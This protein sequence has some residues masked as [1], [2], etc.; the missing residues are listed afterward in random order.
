MPVGNAKERYRRKGGIRSIDRWRNGK[1]PL[2]WLIDDF[3]QNKFCITNDWQFHVLVGQPAEG[4]RDIITL[5]DSQSP[6]I[7]EQIFSYLDYESLIN[8]EKVS[9]DWKD[10]LKNE[11]I[12]KALIKR[13][14]AQDPMWRTF[15]NQF[16]RS[17]VMSHPVSPAGDDIYYMSRKICQE[18]ESLKH[19]YI[20]LVSSSVSLLSSSIT[21]ITRVVDMI[22]HIGFWDSSQESDDC[23]D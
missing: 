12:W 10:V 18:V 15:F 7:V 5:L 4:S 22:K 2:V 23:D 3:E 14:V 19:Q 13:N 11:R 8:A 20:A 1:W 16:K 6:L 21:L 9:T 17:G